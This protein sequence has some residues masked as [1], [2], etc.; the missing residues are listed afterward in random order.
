MKRLLFLFLLSVSSGAFAAYRVAD[1]RSAPD[2]AAQFAS[3]CGLSNGA[4]L[5]GTP[6]CS[7]QWKSSSGIVYT[8]DRLEGISPI[9]ARGTYQNGSRKGSFSTPIASLVYTTDPVDDGGSS[10]DDSGDSGDSGGDSG[11]G[12]SGDGSGDGG[13][14]PTNGECRTGYHLEGLLC[15]PNAENPN[16]PNPD[17]GDSSGGDSGSGDSGSGSSGGDTTD[18]DD[19]DDTTN[20]TTPNNPTDNTGVINAIDSLKNSNQSNFNALNQRLSALNDSSNKV[21]QSIIDQMKQDKEIAQ[22]QLNATQAQINASDAKT[23]EQTDALKG[24]IGETGDEL[25]DALSS[26]QDKLCDPRTDPRGC[27]GENGLTAD[28]TLDMYEEMIAG[29]NKAVSAGDAAYSEA[30]KGVEGADQTAQSQGNIQDVFSLLSVLPESSRCSIDALKT[31]VGTF[32]I[33]CDF[34]NFLKTI[35]SFVFYV[36]TIYYLL[37]ILFDGITPMPGNTSS[38]RGTR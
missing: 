25:A 30:L 38:T 23:D 19:S 4:V 1:V 16:D 32:Q 27:E 17:D 29:A 28:G 12:D 33:G 11:S 7:G 18:P 20:P 21:N 13:E 24:A 8:L 34:A 6:S 35:L 37:D 26:I 5:S 2:Y 15:Y 10:G 3:M 14:L 31:P 22:A 36:G 9:Y